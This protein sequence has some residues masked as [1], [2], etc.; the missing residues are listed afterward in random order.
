MWSRHENKHTI[1]NPKKNNTSNTDYI[2]SCVT[3]QK[4]ILC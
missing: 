4:K 2:E 1:I 3:P